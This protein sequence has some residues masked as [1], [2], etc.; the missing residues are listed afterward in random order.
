VNFT[1]IE[2][3]QAIMTQ[4]IKAASCVF[5]RDQSCLCCTQA[6]A[7]IFQAS[8]ALCLSLEAVTA[9]HRAEMLELEMQRMLD[10]ML[11]M[12]LMLNIRQRWS[13]MRQS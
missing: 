2:Q 6:G 8:S 1:E 11:L 13:L 9:M 10:M 7:A 12:L 3:Q 4:I 5:R